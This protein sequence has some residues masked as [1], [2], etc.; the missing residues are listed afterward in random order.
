[1]DIRNN[2]M[3]ETKLISEYITNYRFAKDYLE[4]GKIDK[5]NELLAVNISH[6]E[7]FDCYRRAKI[8]RAK[9]KVRF[10]LE[11]NGQKVIIKK[12]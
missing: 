3:K 2:N 1:M 10:L 5:A 6:K 8:T 11:N 7:K 12:W 9:N 4:N